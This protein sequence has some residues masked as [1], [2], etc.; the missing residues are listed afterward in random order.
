M[1]NPHTTSRPLLLLLAGSLA[2]CATWPGLEDPSLS[3]SP[4][5]NL[6]RVH[7]DTRMQHNN[8]PQDSQSIES[9]GG[10][11]RDE[12]L[13]ARMTYGDGFSG[14][15]IDYLLLDMEST[16]L[17]TTNQG[18]GTV[19]QYETVN[20]RLAMD[21]VRLRYIAQLPWEYLSDGEEIWLK[22]GVGMQ[23][24]HRELNLTVTEVSGSG[25]VNNS[26][27]IEVKNAA[28]PMLAIRLAGGSGPL[29]VL[30]DYAVND[31]WRIGGGDFK[32]RFF[33][34]AIQANYYLEAQ[35]LTLFGGYRRFDVRAHGSE[36][37]AE[38]Q[39]DFTFDGL[40]FGFRFQF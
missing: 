29:D 7:G 25:G 27:K 2:S 12:E 1:K 26:Q 34:F 35:D 3:I 31:D 13:A 39:T 10:G 16:E 17:G 24:V 21:E 14:F 33:D 22:A 36:G 6:F 9:L 4:K 28:S 40:F 38:Y 11:R 32:K 20:S 15:D 18:W 19:R 5:M 37:P 30:V 23:L 8:V